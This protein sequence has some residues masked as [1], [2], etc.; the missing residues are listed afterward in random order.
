M[1]AW[2]WVMFIWIA[3]LVTGLVKQHGH[4]IPSCFCLLPAAQQH[5]GEAE[6]FKCWRSVH[7]T[8]GPRG[9][10]EPGLLI[11]QLRLPGINS[12]PQ[13]CPLHEIMRLS[14]RQSSH[15]APSAL[16][17]W[18]PSLWQM[19]P[20]KQQTIS[21]QQL[22]QRGWEWWWVRGAEQNLLREVFVLA[23]FLVSGWPRTCCLDQT[24]LELTEIHVAQFPKCWD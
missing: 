1:T 10:E 20:M 19:K 4:T 24:A 6:S 17:H 23:W 21:K 7:A 5:S 14:R 12:H 16:P 18:G 2:A 11:L 13:T 22:P 3:V 8:K 15:V 9:S